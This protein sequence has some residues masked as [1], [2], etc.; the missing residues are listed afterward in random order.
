M[1]VLASGTFTE[2]DKLAP[3][4]TDEIA[5]VHQLRDRGII[6]R[7]YGETRR[8][9]SQRVSTTGRRLAFS[10]DVELLPQLPNALVDTG[11]ELSLVRLAHRSPRFPRSG[12][13]GLLCRLEQAELAGL[14]RRIIAVG[15]RPGT[16]ERRR[17]RPVARRSPSSGGNAATKTSPDDVAEPG[18][19]VGDHRAAVGVADGEDRSEAR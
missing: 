18:R 14:R 5:K 2:R 13:S 16:G 12:V 8:P 11:P 7:P 3:L 10:G 19:R 15:S 6:P 1:Y 9:P 4:L 17:C